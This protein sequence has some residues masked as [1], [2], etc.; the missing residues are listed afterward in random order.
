VS[1]ISKKV[2]ATVMLCGVATA[3]G[4]V[5]AISS[6]GPYVLQTQ[7]IAPASDGLFGESVAMWHDFATGYTW[8]VVGAPLDNAYA[9]AAYVYSAAP[10]DSSWHEEAQLIADDAITNDE[11][12]YSVAIDGDTVVVGAPFHEADFFVG[13]AYVFVRDPASGAWNQQ[14]DTLMRGDTDFGIAVAVSGDE[15]AIGEPDRGR[16]HLYSR[17]SDTWTFDTLLSP[18]DLPLLSGFGSALAMDSEG[19]LLVGAPNDSN[20]AVSQGSAH[21]FAPSRSGWDRQGVLRPAGKDSFQ[22]FGLSVALSDQFAVVGAPWE[23][24][25]AGEAHV[26]AYDVASST[27]SEQAQLQSPHAMHGGLFASSVAVDGYTIAAG[28]P[29]SNS[30]YVFTGPDSTWVLDSTLDGDDGTLFGSTIAMDA[31]MI[32][33]GAPV[34]PGSSD[35]AVYVFLSDRIFADGF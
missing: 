20:I 10:G 9:G 13:A 32:A 27:W 7:L 12:G 18:A 31:G 5:P 35:G 21:L 3:Q 17:S 28:E 24:G 15:V 8:A 34:A 2:A 26:F 33:V 1:S 11:F 19:R 16:V 29:G 14:G 22:L 4:D 23:N 30:V 25:T 6:T